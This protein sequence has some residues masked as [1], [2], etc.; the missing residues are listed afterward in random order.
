MAANRSILHIA[1]AILSCSCAARSRQLSDLLVYAA[2]IVITR[3]EIGAGSGVASCNLLG[4]VPYLERFLSILA[5]T[6]SRSEGAWAAASLQFGSESHHHRRSSSTSTSFSTV[7]A[8]LIEVCTR[9]LALKALLRQN[10]A[11]ATA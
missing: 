10:L 2:R 9:T 5:E 4:D 1:V 3:Y 11:M 8:P 6:L 7:P